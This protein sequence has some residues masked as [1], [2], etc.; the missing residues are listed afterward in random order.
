MSKFRFAIDRGGTFTDI[1]A[2]FSINE[3]ETGFQVL[4]LLSEAPDAYADAP[5]EGIRR[6]LEQV[7]GEFYPIGQPVC[8]KHI[9]RIRMGT[10]VATNAL[11]ERKGARIAFVTTRG[12]RDL[13]EI[14]DQ[15][16]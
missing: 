1:W 3:S 15:S 5:T 2:E 4:K 14:G 10:T 12:F 13:L 8:S 16:R 9:E 6:I 11:L 7:T